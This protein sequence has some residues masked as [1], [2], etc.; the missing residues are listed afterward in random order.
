MVV[1]RERG[2]EPIMASGA[3]RRETKSERWRWVERHAAPGGQQLRRV[4]QQWESGRMG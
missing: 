4:N 2:K 3:A 1:S